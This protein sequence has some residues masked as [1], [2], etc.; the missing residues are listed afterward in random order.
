LYL[1]SGTELISADGTVRLYLG[2]AFDTGVMKD[3]HLRT[4]KNGDLL[5]GRKKLEANGALSAFCHCLLRYC[6]FAGKF[7]LKLSLLAAAQ[8]CAHQNNY[9]WDQANY[10]Q[11]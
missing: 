3:M 9:H 4:R 6:N 5:I 10:N 1:K 8:I 11:H 7:G 2:P